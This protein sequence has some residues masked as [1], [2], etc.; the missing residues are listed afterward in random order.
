MERV[1]EYCALSARTTAEYAYTKG[2]YRRLHVA[3]KARLVAYME[4]KT[5][6]QHRALVTGPLTP[7]PF[8]PTLGL[9]RLLSY[10][11]QPHH[12]RLPQDAST[13]TNAEH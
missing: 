6:H 8:K 1:Q 4:N 2:H 13:E 12:S 7:P 9:T 11:L 3:N 5:K 10:R